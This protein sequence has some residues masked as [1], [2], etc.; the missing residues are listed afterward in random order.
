MSIK[1]FNATYI[2]Q[3]DRVLFRLSTQ[4]GTEFRLWLTR[5]ISM[6]MLGAIRQVIQKDLE[7]K[8]NPQVAQVIQEFQ[9]ERI[10]KTANFREPYK[11]ASKL[12]L[13][14]DP[15]LV[16]GFN[17]GHKNGQ[18]AFTFKLHGDKNLNLQLPSH[19]VQSLIS[20]L[21]QMEIKASWNSIPFVDPASHGA[22]TKSD[23]TDT[24]PIDKKLIH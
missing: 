16:M 19:A 13:G 14:S 22:L 3:E 23:E 7:K 9:E 6:N 11:Q 20:L 2:R 12:P 8:H 24:L 1:Q 17:I 5:L 21:E 10:K 18:F 4:E 15:I